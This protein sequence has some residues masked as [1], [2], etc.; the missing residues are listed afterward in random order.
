M[1]ATHLNQAAYARRVGISRQRVNALKKEGRVV[2]V[3]V[4]S[5]NV[6]MVDVEATDQLLAASESGL[7]QHQARKD[8]FSQPAAAESGTAAQTQDTEA[9][10]PA[11]DVSSR[12]LKHAQQLKAEADAEMAQME[13]DR[14]KG[15][16]VPIEDVQGVVSDTFS[17]LRI[18]LESLPDQIG[19]LVAA[20]HDEGR[21]HAII[22]EQV[23]QSLRHASSRLSEDL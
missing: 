18:T 4:G 13:R 6:L 14:I 8:Q 20:E 2:M 9:D 5:K 7:P 12:R 3:P 1:S 17:V 10:I 19:A 22:A 16:L 15:D 11:L 21:V 23:E